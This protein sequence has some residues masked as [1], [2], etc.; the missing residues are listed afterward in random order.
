MAPWD[1][2]VFDNDG[3]LVDSELLA[4]AV[5]AE[6]LTDEGRPTTVEGSMDRYL[7]GSMSRVRSLV[8]SDGGRP[9]PADF[10]ARYQTVVLHRFRRELQAVPGVAEVIA[11][12]DV[13]HCV[14][15]SGTHERIRVALA[16]VG[17]LAAFEG[18][19][20]SADDVERG[21]PAP[22]LFLHAA[23]ARGA[24]PDRCV[25]IEDSPTGVAAARAAGMTVLGFARRTPA[26][27]LAD[28]HAVFDDMRA[29]PGLLGA[30]TPPGGP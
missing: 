22:D 10:E 12:L 7:G 21:K 15:S 8:E 16:T 28:A 23:A 3:V 24:R 25:V 19:I 6:L 11:G 18:S 9:L 30:L 27:R 20:Y 4:N 17:L 1:L 13:D 29:L 14:A 2:V 5:L 26:A